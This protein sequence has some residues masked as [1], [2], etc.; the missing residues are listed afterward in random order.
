MSQPK[1][2]VNLSLN[3]DYKAWLKN[4]KRKVLRTQLKAAVQVDSTLLAFYWELGEDIIQRQQQTSWDDGFL[5]QFSQDLLVEFPEIK[6]FSLSNIKYIRQRQSD[7]LTR[8]CEWPTAGRRV[9]PGTLR[10]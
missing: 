1:E 10:A 6:G 8:S 5:K 9:N 4:L 2:T 7:L 3:N